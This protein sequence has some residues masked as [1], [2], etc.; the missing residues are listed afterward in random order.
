MVGKD[1]EKSVKEKYDIIT[2]T[3]NRL[4]AMV[5]ER[6]FSIEETEIIVPAHDRITPIQNGM[7][8][9]NWNVTTT[10]IASWEYYYE[11]VKFYIGHTIFE[12]RLSMLEPTAMAYAVL[13]DDGNYRKPQEVIEKF[14][15]KLRTDKKGRN[16]YEVIRDCKNNN[17]E[18]NVCLVNLL[19]M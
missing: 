16:I 17:I 13:T 11:G 10:F 8:I 6:L 9:T 19:I 14:K 3:C 7:Y 5:D 1:A 2:N 4:I 18:T 12:K 15:Q